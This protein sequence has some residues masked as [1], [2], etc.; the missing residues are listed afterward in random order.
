M[1]IS[2]VKNQKNN[3]FFNSLKIKIIKIYYFFAFSFFMI[4]VYYNKIIKIFNKNENKDTKIVEAETEND[5]EEQYYE[6]NID[7]SE[8]STKIKIIALYLP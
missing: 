4:F 5:T 8:Y 2:N 6:K 1:N 7:F 3:Y